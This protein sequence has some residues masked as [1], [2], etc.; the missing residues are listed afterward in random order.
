M[1]T[2]PECQNAYEDE[3]LHCP[4]DGFNL[5]GIEPVDELIGRSIGSYKITKPLG[6]GGMGAVY[7]AEHPIIGS[8][9]AIKFLH[10]QY[11]NDQ[12]IVDR[13]FNEARAVNM[14]GHDNVLKIADLNITDDNRHYFIMEFLQGKALQN[15]VKPNQPIPL[16]VAGPI[17][18]QCCAALQAAH[19][20]GI[21]HRD[22]KPDNIYLIT[23]N[24]R[25][26]FVKVVDF[27]IAK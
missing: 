14:I 27:G 4:E 16:E 19:D 23:L 11:A 2:C 25:K 20:K 24:G 26:N 10:P 9:V 22:L 12:K 7:R 15:I 3:I 18:L 1:R 13:F 8:K 21:I 6:K 17:L 5:S